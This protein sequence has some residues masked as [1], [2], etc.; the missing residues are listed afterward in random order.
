MGVKLKLWFLILSLSATLFASESII[1]KVTSLTPVEPYSAQVF[2]NGNLWLGR[3]NPSTSR[4]RYSIE[5]WD[6]KGERLLTSK[7]ISHSIQFLFVF[8]RTR[9]LFTGKRFTTEEG[10][11]TDYSLASFINDNLQVSTYELPSHFQVEE[12]TGGPEKLFFNMVSDRTLV[13]VTSSGAHPLPLLISGPGMMTQIGDSLFVLERR[14]YG[15]GDEDIVR[16]DLKTLKMD[17]TF[18]A[19]RAGITHILSLHGRELLAAS[20]ALAQQILFIDPSTNTLKWTIPTAGT[21]PQSLA[22]FGHC[23]VVGSSEPVRLTLIDLATEVPSVVDQ[24]DLESHSLELPN[25]ASLHADPETGQFFLRSTGLNNF[26][27]GMTSSIFSFF[28]PDWKLKCSF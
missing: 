12:F 16:V 4:N 25:I 1:K 2:H 19:N 15:M 8:D 27:P 10:W 6:R 26:V 23:L 11:V 5:V 22:Q 9:V 20:E 28:N 17:R 3:V 21:H 18:S 7:A 14:S 24:V 13:E